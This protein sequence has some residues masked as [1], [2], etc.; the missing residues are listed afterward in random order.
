MSG[1]ELYASEALKKFYDGS[2]VTAR[3]EHADLRNY[4]VAWSRGFWRV[5]ILGALVLAC[6][7]V[8]GEKLSNWTDDNLEQIFKTHKIR[9]KSNSYDSETDAL[10]KVCRDLAELENMG[11][12][13]L[14][15]IRNYK[16]R[17]I[18]ILHFIRTHGSMNPIIMANEIKPD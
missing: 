9:S 17:D 3:K 10:I 15:K 16:N 14:D 7:H 11:S 2:F 18:K 6:L 5:S 4:T 1:I 12:G 13:S 8:K